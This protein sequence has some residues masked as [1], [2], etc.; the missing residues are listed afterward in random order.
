MKNGAPAPARPG[1]PNWKA[2]V[3]ELRDHQ[4]WCRKVARSLGLDPDS[5]RAVVI[6]EIL[7]ARLFSS[8]MN[9]RGRRGALIK[10]LQQA[11]KAIPGDS[12]RTRSK[13]ADEKKNL[14]Q[15]LDQLYGPGVVVVE[16]VGD[17]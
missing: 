10:E 4:R 5:P 17:E 15:H 6:R 8:A 3:A 13:A 7:L 2:T 1:D 12:T 16:D 14:R 9:Q 11:L